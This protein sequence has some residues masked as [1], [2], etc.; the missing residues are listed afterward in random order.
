M[1]T[2]D[3]V[4]YQRIDT[5]QR[6][7]MS[8][9]T[10]AAVVCLIAALHFTFWAVNV[11]HA[12][13]PSVDGKLPSV[14]YNRFA[15]YGSSVPEARIRA[16]LAAI[17][18]Q[19]RAVRT[20]S[21]TQ[22]LE[23]VP[24]IAAELGLNVTLGIWIDK[25]NARNEQEILTALEL[26]HRYP[27]VTRLV[28]GNET[29]FRH[30]QTAAS[31]AQIIHRVRQNSPVP[32]AT[33]DHWK[34]FLDNPELVDAVDQVF[35]HILPY[36]GGMPKESAVDGSIEIYD[37]LLKAYP[38]KKIV[39][40]E[41]GWP[42][43][44]HNF[45]RAVAD[46]ISQAVI[47]RNFV[48]NANARDIDYNIVEAI[49]QPEKL[50]EGNVGPYWG[51]FD[52][53]LHPKFAWTGPIVDATYWKNALVAVVTG[54]LLSLTILALPGVT[55][56]QAAILSG[57]DHLCGHWCA[58][59]LVYWQTHYLLLGETISFAIALPVLALLAPIVRSRVSEMAKVSLGGGPT[60][61]LK[62]APPTP[63]AHS[64]KVSIHIPAYREPPDMLLQTIDSVARIDYPNFECVVVINNTPDPAFWE[65]IEARCQELGPRFKFVRIE[66]LA[67]FKAAALRLA[68]A[69]TAADAETI[70]VIDA[71]YV[72]ARNWLKDLVPVFDD[73]NV[74]L[75]QAP[76]DH[77]DGNRSFIHG[78]MNAEYAGFFDVGM[79][80]RNEDNAIIVHG[81]M[82]LI[83]RTALDAAGGWS[84][85]TI[86]EDSDLGL[87]IMEQGWRAHYTTR[88]YGWGLLPQ[89][90]LAFRT[91]RSRWAEGAV[92]IIKKHW[93]QFLPGAGRLDR[94]QKREFLFGWLTWFGADIIAVAAAILNL[95]W[96]PFVVFQV[97]AIPD[98]LLTLPILAAFFISLA[99][100]GCSYTV[101]VAIPYRQMVGAMVMAMSVQWTVASAAIKAAL[102]AR[103]SY[104]HRTR[105]GDG[106]ILD[107]PFA[108]MPEAVLGTL[109]LVGS[110]TIYATN[111][112]RYLE[113]DLL[114]AVLL[115]QSLPFL[116]ALALVWFERSRIGKNQSSFLQHKPDSRNPCSI[117]SP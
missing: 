58:S 36:W 98:A 63:R 110:V 84:S 88:R 26:A 72:V 55:V 93:R 70:G 83:R 65:P 48:V 59:L 67:G 116:S 99:H 47:L 97:V 50:F 49:D 102:P 54:L 73:P 81:T 30:E 117:L 8:L 86:C 90:Y 62:L 80:E 23:R 46:P 60:R 24:E 91:Q 57:L 27:N 66:N 15:D 28:V 92:Q 44:G 42:S 1:K 39:I 2:A 53:S 68:M 77:R 108:A 107:A 113:S 114:A 111:F 85:D 64:P 82:C 109:M 13:A 18:A 87:S 71:D 21:S 11:P 69:E 14:S 37:R 9:S 33:A 104:F 43:E 100:F 35:A 61:L 31:L 115:I 4:Q 41:F 79:V 7:A 16:D 12:N 101:R 5:G 106:T 29:M 103:Q 20:Y 40:G 19:A 22:G 52:A 95:I 75:V 78:A 45:E 6:Q 38:G 94:D 34:F 89:D 17:A 74:G 10:F 3:E 32:V 96:V 56:R 105:K 25:N 112:H 76:Q 51:I